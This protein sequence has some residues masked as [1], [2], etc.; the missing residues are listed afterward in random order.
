MFTQE[1]IDTKMV[2]GSFDENALFDADE[3][4][5]TALDGDIDEGIYAEQDIMTEACSDFVIDTMLE[6]DE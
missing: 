5:A 2:D 3:C 4:V 6:I 1:F